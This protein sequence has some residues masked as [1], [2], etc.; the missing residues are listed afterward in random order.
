MVI[1]FQGVGGHV[2]RVEAAIAAFNEHDF[3]LLV[4]FCHPEV[5]WTPPEELP[6]SRTYHGR[7]G[8]REAAEDMISIFGDLRAEPVRLEERGDAVVGL[9][10]WRGTASGSG[11]PIDP[12]EVRA[13]FVCEFEA[14]LF[15]TVRF[16]T[17]WESPLEA[18]GLAG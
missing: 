9:Y 15:R 18:A 12:F 3:D 2:A 16:W 8:V 6:G 7:D 1:H 17:N 13:G 10:V 5:D 14:D 4:D 11:A